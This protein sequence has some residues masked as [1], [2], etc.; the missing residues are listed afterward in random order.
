MKEKKKKRQS[1]GDLCTLQLVLNKKMQTINVHCI[2]LNLD[3]VQLFVFNLKLAMVA[4][5]LQIG[6]VLFVPSER[7]I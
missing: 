3:S 2:P 7:E 4:P 1:S 6:Y 5:S